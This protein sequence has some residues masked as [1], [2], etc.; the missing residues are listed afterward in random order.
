[1]KKY[2]NEPVDCIWTEEDI[3]KEYNNYHNK[4]S[5]AKRYLITVKEVTKILNRNEK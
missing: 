4:K 1:M 5:V 3:I 2:M